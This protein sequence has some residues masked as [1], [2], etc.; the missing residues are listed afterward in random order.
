MSLNDGANAAIYGPRPDGAS[1]RECQ[2]SATGANYALRSGYRT[3]EF[4]L[5]TGEA[6]TLGADRRIVYQAV[7]YAANRIEFGGKNIEKICIAIFII[8]TDSVGNEVRELNHPRRLR[9]HEQR[10][11]RQIVQLTPTVSCNTEISSQSLECSFVGRLVQNDQ[12]PLRVSGLV[13]STEVSI[14]AVTYLFKGIFH[15]IVRRYCRFMD[16]RAKDRCR[17]SASYNLQRFS[18]DVIPLVFWDSAPVFLATPNIGSSK[19]DFLWSFRPHSGSDFVQSSRKP[20][21]SPLKYGYTRQYN[22][23]IGCVLNGTRI[24]QV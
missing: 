18:I 1:R 7:N 8:P 3:I 10:N 6:I 23:S 17:M 13:E 24:V 21:R 14:K 15:R 5:A 9:I 20:V 4:R 16:C 11:I 19:F 12:T 22:M 2:A